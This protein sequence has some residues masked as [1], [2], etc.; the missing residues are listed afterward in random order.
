[1]EVYFHPLVNRIQYVYLT[2]DSKEAAN[3]IFKNKHIYELKLEKYDV[4]IQC[5]N[6][7]MW[8]LLD[9]IS[10][11]QNVLVFIKPISSLEIVM[12]LPNGEEYIRT[13]HHLI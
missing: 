11:P 8:K 3:D 10:A 13:I 5:L 4:Q 2:L 12:N 7:S 1:M 6:E 9:N